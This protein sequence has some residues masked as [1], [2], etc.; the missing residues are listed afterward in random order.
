MRALP[1]RRC[2]SLRPLREEEEAWATRLGRVFIL[3]RGQQIGSATL[4]P[5]TLTAKNETPPERL[6]CQGGTLRR[7]LPQNDL[8]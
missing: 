3:G 5:Q 4:E 8:L 2:S 7:V 1:R 6:T